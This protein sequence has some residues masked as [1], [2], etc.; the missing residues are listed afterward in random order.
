MEPF[1]LFG[2]NG[3]RGPWSDCNANGSAKANGSYLSPALAGAYGVAGP[4]PACNMY[5]PIY[6]GLSIN[7]RGNDLSDREA[8]I[9]MHFGI[10]HHNDSGK[11]TS[12]SYSTTSSTRRAVG[13]TS[14]P[15]AVSA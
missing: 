11:T 1:T 13:T 8:V 6:G 14:A 9:N 4:M 7:L 2:F 5:G 3:S 10:P 12:K 15:T